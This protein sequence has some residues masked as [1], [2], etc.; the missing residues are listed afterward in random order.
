MISIIHY[1]F[2]KHRF[3]IVSNKIWS[4]RYTEV[5]KKHFIIHYALSI[6]NLIQLYFNV[7]EY[8]PVF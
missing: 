6:F 3:Y 7:C 1:N 2:N 5:K 4:I 8:D